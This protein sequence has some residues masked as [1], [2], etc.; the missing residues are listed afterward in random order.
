MAPPDLKRFRG[1]C[2]RAQTTSTTTTTTGRA[3]LWESCLRPS[4]ARSCV[5]RVCCSRP[6][7]RVYPPAPPSDPKV[8]DG[9][10]LGA[11]RRPCRRWLEVAACPGLRGPPPSGRP[12]GPYWGRLRQTVAPKWATAWRKRP[13]AAGRQRRNGRRWSWSS[14][15]ASRLSSARLRCRPGSS[16]T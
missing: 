8:K 11:V 15:T 13:E 1:R 6:S 9:G 2:T 16:R 3:S 7:G 4:V 5:C 14:P 12:T 10:P